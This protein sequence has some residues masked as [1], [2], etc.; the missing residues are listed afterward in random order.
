M[1]GLAKQGSIII[2]ENSQEVFDKVLKNLGKTTE[3][4][5]DEVMQ[6]AEKVAAYSLNE[7]QTKFGRYRFGR[8]DGSSAGRNRS[9]KMITSL[10]SRKYSKGAAKIG[11]SYSALIGWFGGPKYFE[12]QELGTGTGKQP[13]QYSPGFKYAGSVKGGIAGAHSLWT[14]RKWIVDNAAVIFAK[15]IARG[16]EK[17]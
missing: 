1:T 10:T 6:G 13:S 2:V 11:S 4:F 15:A 7:A 16:I 8:G 14:A 12:Y 9:G 3:V 17:G 5:V